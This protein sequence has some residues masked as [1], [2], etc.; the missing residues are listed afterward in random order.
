LYSSSSIALFLPYFHNLYSSCSDDEEPPTYATPAPPPSPAATN[1]PIEPDVAPRATRS[2]VKKVP[3]AQ[4]R[5]LKRL[6]KAKETDVSLEAHASTVSSDD[7]SNSSFLA[8]FSYT[9][10]LTRSFPQAL[11][12]RF[13]A[14]GTECAGYLKVTKASEGTTFDVQSLLF[15]CALSFAIYL[16]A[17]HLLL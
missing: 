4:A 12:K 15:F 6:K 10:S 14:L 3:Q 7:V 17:F 8:F 16:T 13:I 11:V 1:E 5:N 2:S 9:P